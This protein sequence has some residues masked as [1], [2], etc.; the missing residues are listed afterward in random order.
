MKK[1]KQVYR[2]RLR[3]LDHW[4][5]YLLKEARL[6]DGSINLE[7]AGVVADEG[8]APLFERLLGSDTETASG[9]F[10]VVCGVLGLGTLA[11]QGQKD[12]VHRLRM[13]A[14]DER[15][16]V[17]DAVPA[18]LQRWG[19]YDMS[20]L[21]HEMVRW[22]EGN[23]YEQR[24]AIAALCER[25][26]LGK[27]SDVDKTLA[28][29]DRVTEGLHRG[30]HRGDGDFRALRSSLAWC[31][32]VAVAANPAAG[33]RV[34]ARWLTCNDPDVLWVMKENLKQQSLQKMDADWVEAARLVLRTLRDQP[35]RR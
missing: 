1:K 32:S 26:L 33:K 29:L 8:D 9:D 31:W 10:L 21:S 3:R 6:A 16:T 11:T 12:A 20:A 28:V 5:T 30:E 15:I 24:A 19:E 25:R 7:L 4:D 35:V 13:Y 18:A 2:E 14:S 17:R 34:M 22:A 23:L 27:V